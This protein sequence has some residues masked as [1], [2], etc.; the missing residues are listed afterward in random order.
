MGLLKSRTRLRCLIL[1]PLILTIR[2]LPNQ[3]VN[4]LALSISKI[5]QSNYP[6]SL[7][8]SVGARYEA[9]M[10]RVLKEANYDDGLVGFYQATTMGAFLRQS[11]ISS[12][13]LHQD[14][15]RQGGIALV[16][17]KRLNLAY[18]MVSV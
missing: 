17:G 18:I 12:Q 3:R 9:S 15:L 14:A 4:P 6:T 16:H 5:P 1:L 8:S 7:T 2:P 13:I 11:F 10:L